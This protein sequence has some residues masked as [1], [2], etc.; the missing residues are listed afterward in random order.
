MYIK[1]IGFAT[2]LLLCLISQADENRC[3]PIDISIKPAKTVFEM[4][5]SPFEIWMKRDGH[6]RHLN[7]SPPFEKVTIDCR[8][9]SHITIQASCDSCTPKTWSY[10]T[11]T[12][13]ELKQ[14]PLITPVTCE[15][16]AI[17]CSDTI[18]LFAN[19]S[20]IPT[21]K[22]HFVL[23]LFAKLIETP[24]SM[25]AY[26]STGKTNNTLRKIN[27]GNSFHGTQSWVDSN[28]RYGVSVNKKHKAIA[29]HGNVDDV[30]L[31]EEWI[32]LHFDLVANT[33]EK[34]RTILT[35]YL[36]QEIIPSNLI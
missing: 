25:S 30:G 26:I 27:I 21:I 36:N 12:F 7:I 20:D 15:S 31:I 16:D 5:Y 17:I 28:F 24:E 35:E 11:Q 32:N 10:S 13:S 8:Q 9:K 29:I 1:A 6:F 34:T 33:E 4:Y 2:L 23:A 19:H 22:S 3:Q 14:Q 18:E